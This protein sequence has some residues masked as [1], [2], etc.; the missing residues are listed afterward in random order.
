M[1]RVVLTLAAPGLLMLLLVNPY[2]RGDGNGYY[3]WLTSPAIDGDV[4]FGNQYLRADPAFRA[5][6]ID[7]AG[8]PTARM[9]TATGKVENQWSVGPALLWLPPFAV[10]HALALTGMGVPDGYSAVY[11]FLVAASTVIYGLLSLVI[12]AD[13]AR[14]FGYERHAPLA[15]LAVLLASS[16][17][18]YMTVLPFHVHAL[19]AFSGAVFF[20]W[21][22]VRVQ[23]WEAREWGVWGLASGLLVAVYYVQAVFLVLVIARLA[24]RGTWASRAKAAVAFGAGMLPFA[25]LHV[26]S[27]LALYGSATTTGYRDEFFWFSPRLLA[28]ALSPEH[29]LF[30]WT[31]V[32]ALALAG[33]VRLAMTDS[34]ARAVLAVWAVLFYVIACYQNWH[35]Q[36]SFGNRFF[37]SLT[38]V[39][40]P[41][42]AAALAW[43][44]QRWRPA[45][46]ATV[47]VLALW[48]AGFVFQW[49][50]NL[51]PNRGPVDFSEVARNQV[52]E[53]P[54]RLVSTLQRYLADRRAVAGDVDGDDLEERR[55]YKLQR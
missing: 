54:S 28:V 10:A 42:V 49:A 44:H 9:R 47:L 18:V 20:W 41:G 25:A 52:T 53:V 36:S 7:E 51:V 15:A 11:L 35:G 24:R 23:G 2:V 33:L 6:F 48:N 4:H 1:K 34:R 17:P 26:A 32:I 37:V 55:K 12:G 16:L 21:G 19:A 50:F 14:R 45:P 39:F 22:L 46:A 31:P 13:L 27:R 3:A 30:L 5:G 29:G 43:L 8:Q 38:A 40:V